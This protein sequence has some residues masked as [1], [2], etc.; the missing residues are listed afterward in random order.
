MNEAEWRECT[1]PTTMLVFL[2]GKAS[3]RKLRLFNCACCRCMWDR[4]VDERSRQAVEIAE[5]FADG[6]T[7][8]QSRATNWSSAYHAWIDSLRSNAPKRIKQALFL[9]C[10]AS[11]DTVS[12]GSVGVP[13]DVRLRSSLLRDIFGNSFRPV[14]VDPAWLTPAV[15][16]LTHTIYDERAFDRLPALADSLEDVGCDNADILTHCRGSGPHVRGCWVVDLLL[17]KE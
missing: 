3:D 6:I 1:D 9:A 4:M 12:V 13:I 14:T 16:E 10:H 8:E 11:Q 7:S 5:Q 15:V 17:G 2:R